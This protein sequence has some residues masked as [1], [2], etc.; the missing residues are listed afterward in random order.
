MALPALLLVSL[1]A[2]LLIQL[3]PG[4]P[5]RLVAGEEAT[6]EQLVAIR[7]Q[8]GFD[9]PVVRQYV[10]WMGSLL[11]GDLGESLFTGEDVTSVITRRLP[12]SL[13]LTVLALGV[14][15]VGG[16]LIGGLAAATAGSWCDRACVVAMSIGLAVPGFWLAGMLVVVFVVQL[17]WF[18]VLGYSPLRESP[19]DWVRHLALPAV[20]LG[21]EPAAELAR[22]ARGALVDALRQDYVRTARSKG[23]RRFQVFAKH[24]A[25]N[26]MIPVVTVVGTQA[27]RLLGGAVVIEVMFGLPGIGTLAIDAVLRSDIPVIQGVVLV[28]ALSVLIINAIVDVSYYAL[29]PRLR[30]Q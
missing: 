25:K 8:F 26:A 12:V 21:V 19:V 29:D 13:S 16:L 10:S 5:A 20:A 28:G 2:F 27:A 11:R 30:A 23:L 9:Q 17:G 15:V 3:V 22:H 1:L 14:A 24:A 4:D 18:P 6:E 7:S